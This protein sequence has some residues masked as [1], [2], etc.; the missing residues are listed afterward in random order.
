MF[1]KYCANVARWIF[2]LWYLAS[3]S[4]WL[5]AHALGRGTVH[6]EVSPSAAAFQLALAQSQ[7]MD[8][9]LSVACLLGGIALLVPR[10]SPLGI[11]ILAPVVVAIF[12]FH[13]VLSGNWTWGSLNLVWFAALA[14]HFRRAF[15]PLWHYAEPPEAS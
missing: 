14:W 13:L 2:S 5:I 1:L 11:V 8:P 6:H 4:T 3:G 10:T 12:L 15:A 7:F 9:L